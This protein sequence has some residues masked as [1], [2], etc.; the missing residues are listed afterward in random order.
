M[1]LPPVAIKNTSTPWHADPVTWPSALK[2]TP[3][4]YGRTLRAL[5]LFCTDVGLPFWGQGAS[6]ILEGCARRVIEADG[7]AL[8]ACPEQIKRKNNTFVECGKAGPQA[9]MVPLSAEAAEWLAS[10]S[11]DLRAPAKVTA[12]MVL[13]RH[14]RDATA[15][16]A[17]LRAGGVV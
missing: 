6:V 13:Y 9:V 2:V 8:L 15:I 16:L 11:I 17:A 12:A 14:V 5:H 4:L 1:I 7:P 3:R 10:A